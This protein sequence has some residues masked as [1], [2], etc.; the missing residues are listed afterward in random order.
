MSERVHIR[1]YLYHLQCCI[2]F[3]K[4]NA[5][6]VAFRSQRACILKN[7]SVYSSVTPVSQITCVDP[8]S[9]LLTAH[10]PVPLCRIILAH[11]G[12]NLANHVLQG[13]IANLVVSSIRKSCHHSKP[14]TNFFSLIVKRIFWTSS[15]PP[16]H[17]VLTQ[18]YKPN[19]LVSTSSF[20]ES[21]Q[22]SSKSDKI[23]LPPIRRNHIFVDVNV[24]DV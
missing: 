14:A 8:Y 16:K 11:S 23:S 19:T 20:L 12:N 10:T 18:T 15:L 9:H 24:V 1:F 22:V 21:M 6:G 13:G 2:E 3:D 5:S 17:P 7:I 4:V